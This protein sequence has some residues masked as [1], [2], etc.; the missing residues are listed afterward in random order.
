M[1]SFKDVHLELYSLGSLV[2]RASMVDLLRMYAVNWWQEQDETEILIET[3]HTLRV[4]GICSLA[5]IFASKP[6]KLNN[7][8]CACSVV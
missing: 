6:P 1:S 8:A 3:S 4:Y 7:L 5:P 2:T